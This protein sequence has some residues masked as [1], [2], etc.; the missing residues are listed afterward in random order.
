MFNANGQ[1][2]E[3]ALDGLQ[4]DFDTIKA[5]IKRLKK[6]GAPDSQIDP[7]RAR[8][9]NIK[10]AMGQTTFQSRMAAQTRQAGLFGLSP[11]MVIG[12]IAALAGGM[13]LLRKK[14]KRKRGRRR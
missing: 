8:K 1:D 9:N 13:I 11:V 5:E 3:E 7:L 10:L 14:P 6:A 2:H 4:E 12:G